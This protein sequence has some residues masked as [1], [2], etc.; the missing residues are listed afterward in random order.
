MMKEKKAGKLLGFM[1]NAKK[2]GNRVSDDSV[3]SL[4]ELIKEEVG[5]YKLTKEMRQEAA[6]KFGVDQE[7]ANGW[8]T[9]VDVLDHI[10]MVSLAEKH[11][12]KITSIV[13]AVLD[14]VGIFFP[15]ASLASA[16]VE[17][18]PKESAAKIVGL[19][20][21]ATPEHVLHS[22]AKKK[23]SHDKNLEESSCGFIAST[24]DED[25]VAVA[26]DIQEKVEKIVAEK[27]EEVLDK[28]VVE[29]NL[30][31]KINQAK[32]LFE[33]GA[34]TEEE[35]VNIKAKLIEKM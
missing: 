4:Y 34:I 18:M 26:L 5:S 13:T 8:Q 30:F 16:A 14:V 9:V 32:Q 3:N 20:A 27:S 11:P 6:A 15:I 19:L 23:V 21:K 1:A 12:E 24:K 35:F 31:E 22:I 25:S 7:T 28:P 17:R 2:V 10:D 33:I 29:E